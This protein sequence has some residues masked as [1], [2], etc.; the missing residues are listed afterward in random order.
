VNIVCGFINHIKALG[1]E[2]E[3]KKA[4]KITAYLV[5]YLVYILNGIQQVRHI[6]ELFYAEFYRVEDSVDS[7][8]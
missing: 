3:F 2:L 6:E 4:V 5:A 8:H 7:G 1:F